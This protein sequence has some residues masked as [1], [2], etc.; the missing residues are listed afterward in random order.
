MY[1]Y[2]YETTNL[3]NGMKYIGQHKSDVFDPSYLGSGVRLNKA[4]NKYGRNN[5]TVELITW[6]DT[7]EELDWEEKKCIYFWKQFYKT[8]LY[9]D[10][11][12]GDGGN[13]CRYKSKEEINE[14]AKR[15]NK[16]LT[17]QIYIHKDNILKRVNPIDFENIYKKDGW[18]RGFTKEL[19]E[20]QKNARNY[21]VII[22]KLNKV[23]I[24]EDRKKKISK[25]VK[26]LWCNDAYRELQS[27]SHK[28][29]KLSKE[30]KKKISDANKGRKL[31]EETKSKIGKSKIGNK[32]CLGHKHTEKT[33]EKIRQ[34][35]LGK[36]FDDNWK[37]NLANAK[38]GKILMNNGIIAKYINRVEEQDYLK[39]GWKRGRK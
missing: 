38:K 27:N 2:I 23:E 22:S 17:G 13:T 37:E 14:I 4:I 3:I 32:Y 8:N 28:G 12:G 21:D 36:K 26:K 11:S 30:S 33:K 18:E 25:S 10:A 9:N 24:T 19:I 35:K 6:K 1:G 7:K 39:K 34:Q 31:S 20:K 29:N 16:I 15:R 5:F